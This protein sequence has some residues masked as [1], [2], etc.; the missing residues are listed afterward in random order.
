MRSG[1][2]M[3]SDSLDPILD[4]AGTQGPQLHRADLE[5]VSRTVT[6]FDPDDFI[7]TVTR[8]CGLSW[9]AGRPRPLDYFEIHGDRWWVDLSAPDNRK[10]LVV[11]VAAAALVDALGLTASTSWV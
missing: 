9:E 2:R 10:Q 6:T 7:H 4:Y 8:V 3:P 1:I 5:A 11:A